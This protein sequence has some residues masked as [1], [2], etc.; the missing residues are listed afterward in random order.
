MKIKAGSRVVVTYDLFRDDVGTVTEVFPP[1]I[2]VKLD[3]MENDLTLYEDEVLLLPPA[4]QPPK[5]YYGLMNS[6]GGWAMVGLSIA[7]CLALTSCPA[8][9]D[10]KVTPFFEGGV[11]RMGCGT[12]DPRICDDDTM[13]S[14]WPATLG[15]GFELSDCR[16]LFGA[17]TCTIQWHHQSYFD[18]GWPFNRYGQESYLD[19]YGINLRWKL[20]D[21][22]FSIF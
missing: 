12:T 16:Y 5:L 22:S 3:R 2:R 9:A 10:V 17:D 20:D 4:Q 1:Y 15:A 14:N 8:K 11:Y 18:R 7:F 19:M 21:L 13:G 6:L